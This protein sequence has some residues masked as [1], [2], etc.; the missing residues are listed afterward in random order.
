[1]HPC[2]DPLIALRLLCMQLGRVH[3]FVVFLQLVRMLGLPGSRNGILK[4]SLMITRCLK[5]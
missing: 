3:Q 1:M 4:E 5:I 2:M